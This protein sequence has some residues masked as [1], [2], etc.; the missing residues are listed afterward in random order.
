[1]GIGRF[2]GFQ[3]SRRI[4][5]KPSFLQLVA[6]VYYCQKRNVHVHLSAG[7]AGFVCACWRTWRGLELS[8]QFRLLSSNILSLFGIC[9]II[10]V[11]PDLLLG[12]E[13]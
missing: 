4:H 3:H 2:V 5:L 7:H 6:I 12:E 11:I 13:R 9:V 1:M 10:G 8:C